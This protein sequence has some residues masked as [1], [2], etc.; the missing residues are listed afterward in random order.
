MEK[1][2]FIDNMP[3][4]N[5][6]LLVAGFKGWG[7]ALDV[8]HQMADYLVQK[9]N[10]I[11]F[12]RINADLFYRYDE[13]RP[14]ISVINGD[15]KNIQPPGGSFHAV[16]TPGDNRDL[17]VLAA[18]E[19]ALGWYR[20]KDDLISLCEELGVETLITLG[21]MFDNVLHTDRIISGMASSQKL[22][23][24]LQEHHVHPI[25][26]QGPSAIHSLIQAEAQKRGMECFSLWTHCP[27]YLEMPTHYGLQAMFARLL[28]DIGDFELDTETLEAQWREMNR[29]IQDVIDIN[30]KLQEMVREIRK[31]KVQ[32]S[33]A[34]FR[35]SGGGGGVV[36][37]DDKVI[38]IKDF[39][40]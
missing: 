7:N 31:N 1:G 24:R 3:R 39:L 35:R 10:G 17:V 36:Q 37:T 32:G 38:Q 16:H 4:L 20:F 5:R 33:K 29:K 23:D 9:M 6:P 22:L 2:I 11:P 34:N 19:P 8:A 30:P 14:V 15:L 26:Y 28:S 21:S 18:D 25:A 13:T 40:E 12:A 27:Y